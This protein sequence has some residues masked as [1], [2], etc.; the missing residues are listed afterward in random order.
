MILKH[1]AASFITKTA[2]C[3]LGNKKYSAEKTIKN[4]LIVKI[5]AD[6]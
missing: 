4:N 1:A 3:F 6:K 5:S 2:A